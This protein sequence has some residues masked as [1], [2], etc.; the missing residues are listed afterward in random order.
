MRP[1][2]PLFLCASL[3]TSCGTRVSDDMFRHDS[4]DAGDQAEIDAD[5]T[6]ISTGGTDEL[7]TQPRFVYLDGAL[8]DTNRARWYWITG[9]LAPQ[10]IPTVDVHSI[11]KT[12]ANLQVVVPADSSTG[13]S[14]PHIPESVK[15]GAQP[16]DEA[17]KK[18]EDHQVNQPAEPIKQ[19][20]A[21]VPS[22]T[23]DDQS[24]PSSPPVKSTRDQSIP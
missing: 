5:R 24:P 15:I 13:T 7:V 18:E 12:P 9:G 17:N 3:M 21:V 10:A 23:N 19:S 2:I 1:I 22:T 8:V 4:F 20:P 11:Q 16:Q 14:T 6:R